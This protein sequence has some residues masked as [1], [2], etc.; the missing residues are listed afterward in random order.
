VTVAVGEFVAVWVGSG[1][2]V[3]S[4]VAVFVAE[5]VGEGGKI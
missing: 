5:G 2:I 4:A 1:V 3:G